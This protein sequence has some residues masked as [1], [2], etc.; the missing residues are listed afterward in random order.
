MK[1]EVTYVVAG[2]VHTDTF[3]GTRIV[4]TQNPVREHG[5]TVIVYDDLGN[6]TEVAMYEQMPKARFTY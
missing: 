4:A 3:V 5:G 2:T 6:R 1:C